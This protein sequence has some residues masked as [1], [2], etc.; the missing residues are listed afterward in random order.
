MKQ[1]IQRPT[2][3]QQKAERKCQAENVRSMLAGNAGDRSFAAA[4]SPI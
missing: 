2:A 1:E 4:G 3:N